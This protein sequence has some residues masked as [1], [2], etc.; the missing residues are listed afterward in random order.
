MIFFIPSRD[1]LFL[2]KDLS[3][4][5]AAEII[6]ILQLETDHFDS[7]VLRSSLYAPVPDAV[8]TEEEAEE[9]D[10]DARPKDDPVDV[11]RQVLEGDGHG[12]GVIGVNQAQTTEAP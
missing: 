3:P 11:D 9:E 1:C 2:L 10:T 7:F 5:P 4:Q 6:H 8:T 12:A